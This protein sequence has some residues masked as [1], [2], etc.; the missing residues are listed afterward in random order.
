MFRK[1]ADGLKN[2][3]SAATNALGVTSDDKESQLVA[4]GVANNRQEATNALQATNGNVD[5][6]AELLLAQRQHDQHRTTANPTNNHNHQH[7]EDEDLR[8]ALQ[9]SMND[10]RTTNGQNR[11]ESMRR[12]AT[13]AEVRNKKTPPKQRTAA[14][15]KAAQAA[16]ARYEHGGTNPH[17]LSTAA[18]ALAMD[19][20]DVKVVPKLQDKTIEEQILRCA[21]RLKTSPA[22]VDTLYRACTTIQQ[23]PKEDKYRT[24]DTTTAGFQRSL[25]NAPGAVDF[26]KGIHFHPSPHNSDLLRLDLVDPARIY[27]GVSALEQTK[28]TPEYIAGKGR[29]VLTKE[30]AA[31]RAQANTSEAEALKRAAFMA[32]CPSEP[33]QGQ[34]AWMQIALADHETIRRRFDGDDTLQDVLN[35]LGSHASEIPTKLTERSW[36]L[37][38]MNRY[39]VAPLDC[40]KHASY[41]L[42][43]LGCFPS[44]RLE[45]VPSTEQWKSGMDIDGAPKGS[46]RGLGAA[47]KEAL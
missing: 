39:P 11:N 16:E 15:H 24:I 34:G 12:A 26:L 18:G 37:Q 46:A 19:H 9:A 35:W 27:L 23:H 13:A 29:I 4:M 43:Y 33:A 25:A 40:I 36:M 38:D 28:R 32:K 3:T 5:Q 31:L 17:K 42:Q 21:D 14:M 1:L 6:A 22:A 47:P 45:I 44:G 7:D 41:T 30:I 10:A 8:R 20:P 2:A